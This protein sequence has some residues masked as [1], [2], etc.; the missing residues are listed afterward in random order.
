MARV[1]LGS[2]RRSDPG[3]S[4]A[5]RVNFS[6]GESAFSRLPVKALA[7]KRAVQHWKSERMVSGGGGGRGTWNGSTAT[8]FPLC[9]RRNRQ[10]SAYDATAFRHNFR[11]ER[12]MPTAQMYLPKANKMNFDATAMMTRGGTR[13]LAQRATVVSQVEATAHPNLPGG[14]TRM[15]RGKKDWKSSTWVLRRR[16]RLHLGITEPEPGVPVRVPLSED[17]LALT[18]P[19]RRAVKKY[20][21]PLEREQLFSR[22]MRKA[23]RSVLAKRDTGPV[24]T[25]RED[26]SGSMHSTRT[27][28]HRAIATAAYDTVRRQAMEKALGAEKTSRLWDTPKPG[29]V[30]PSRPAVGLKHTYEHS[31]TWE[32]NP[33]EK[34]MMWSDT[35]SEVKESRGDQ[36]KV[37]DPFRYNFASPSHM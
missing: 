36:H 34:R 25:R 35:G 23:K 21:S 11:A 37:Y 24:T 12:V 32:M 29:R 17:A 22:A 27:F 16:T 13:T 3:A 5:G 6:R 33:V 19:Q 1:S 26:A 14:T 31:G 20:V 9:V 2:E 30:S 10:I 28:R 4:G 18:R 8:P 7:R 15:G